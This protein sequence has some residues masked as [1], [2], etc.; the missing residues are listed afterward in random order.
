MPT[1]AAMTV[2]YP[3]HI[4]AKVSKDAYAMRDLRFPRIARTHMIPKSLTV[5]ELQEK[6]VELHLAIEVA[7]RKF[8]RETGVI[9]HVDRCHASPRFEDGTTEVDLTVYCGLS[10]GL[11]DIGPPNDVERPA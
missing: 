9:A 6:R 3:A 1:A 8:V 4:R 7:L 2:T 5:L 11:E 10:P